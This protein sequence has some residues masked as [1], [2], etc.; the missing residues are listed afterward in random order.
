M[1]EIIATG[2]S[3]RPRAVRY[4]KVQDDN[5]YEMGAGDRSDEKRVREKGNFIGR[6]G[7]TRSVARG[8]H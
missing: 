1:Q 6:V 2:H 5:E 4:S 7:A 3:F 8:G